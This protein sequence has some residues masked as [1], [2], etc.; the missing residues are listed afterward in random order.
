MAGLI[1]R[2]GLGSGM[3]KE[4][5]KSIPE[6]ASTTLLCALSP[7]VVKGGYYYDC[8]LSQGENMHPKATDADMATKLWD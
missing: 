8:K 6:G 3:F 7:D 1:F 4:R 5:F 2:K